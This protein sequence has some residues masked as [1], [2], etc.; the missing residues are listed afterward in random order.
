[1]VCSIIAVC[2][3]LFN[4]ATPYYSD[5]WWY[6]FIHQ[7]DYSYP[8]ERV[9]CIG[10]ILTS[11]INHY[12][13]V[14]GR[15]PVTFLVQSVVSFCPKS[16]FNIL[17]TIFFVIATLLTARLA[18]TQRITPHQVA[19]AATALFF[20][21]PGHYEILMWATGAI[22]YLWVSTL[23]LL[24]LLLWRKLLVH[25]TSPYIYP[26][27]L[28]IGFAAGW[29]NEALSFG[30]AAGVTIEIL[31][32][33]KKLHASHGWL[34]AGVIAGACMILLAPGS[35]NRLNTISQPTF[36]IERYHPL[37]WALITPTLL[38][39]GLL[40][41]AKRKPDVLKPFVLQHRICLTAAIVL[42]PVCT[43]T[44]Q[45]AG[46]SFY[47][48][49]LF[50]LIPL[51]A[52]CNRYLV[53]RLSKNATMILYIGAILF[54]GLI[55]SEHCR[56]EQVHRTLIDT[57]A[58]STYGNVAL[59]TPQRA[60]YATPYTI[61]LDTE[62]RLGHTAQHMAAYYQ[63][64]PLQWISVEQDRLLN[65]PEELFTTLNKVQGNNGLYTTDAIEYYVLHPTAEKQDSL[66]YHYTQVSFNDD[67]PLHSRLR[68]LIAP[69]RYPDYETLPA[70]NT[71]LRVNNI[72]YIC[73]PKNRY[74]NVTRIEN[75]NHE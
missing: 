60:W 66:E 50:C 3:Y 21:M 25:R 53:P 12:Q 70:Y 38:A 28:L 34:A 71:T 61:N 42:M 56:L 67:V 73:I 45:Y 51:L 33:H 64:N 30:L 5:D 8:T 74:R 22:N 69:N 49:A 72:D 9:E 44:Y 24:V 47:G 57:Y 46:R 13:T 2:F 26:L 11:Q 68:R 32:G 58:H 16:I 36:T 37:L 4:S 59:D 20:L 29:S 43:A 39:I 65:H 14:N 19:A 23:I 52:L 31:L 48:M 27:L 54:T 6:T 35:W 62:Y 17:N 63:G 1:M 41:V 10:D 15:F 18:T 40:V 7:A 75:C 55:Y